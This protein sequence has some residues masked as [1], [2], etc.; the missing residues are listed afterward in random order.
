M[1]MMTKAGYT[2]PKDQPPKAE[3]PVK[4][5]KKKKKRISGAVIASL[6]ILL[7]AVLIGAGTLYIYAQTG[8]YVSAY[9][10]G[11]HL[12]GYQLGGATREDAARLLASLTQESVAAWRY[13]LTFGEK[14]Y[15]ITAQDAKLGVDEAATLDPLWAL[16]REG[17]M[18]GRLTAMIRLA[19]EPQNAN[20]VIVYDMEPVDALL[21]TVKEEIDRGPVDAG[22]TYTPDSSEPFS[23]TDEVGGLSLDVAPLRAQIEQA[24]MAMTPGSMELSPQRIEPA[25]TKEQ[26]EAACVLRARVRMTA[27]ADEAAAANIALAAGKLNGLTLAP[28]E[29]LSFNETVGARTAEAGYLDAAEEAY[30]AGVSGV[31]GGVCAVSTALYRAAL[32]AGLD[33]RARSAA[34]RPVSYCE[35]G[36][37]AAVSGQGLDLVIANNTITPVYLNAA[38]YPSDEEGTEGVVVEVEW[39]GAPLESTYILRTQAL[40]TDVIEEPVY[41]RDREGRYAKYTDEKVP[42]GDGEP[43]FSALVERVTLDALGQEIGSETISEDIYEAV[44]PVIYVGVQERE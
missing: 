16:G 10:P 12:A 20:P 30:G 41:V 28:G 21:A 26:L 5:K 32:M 43:G 25:V 18:L 22:V 40:E 39:I 15:S 4:K 38:V 8:P 24:L 35:M 2:P 44:A 31:G 1:P 29:A 11:T 37:E 42:A 7:A 19:A 33:I 13:D 17:G 3:P 9:L 14:M 27:A 23:Y 36:Q 6:V 34:V